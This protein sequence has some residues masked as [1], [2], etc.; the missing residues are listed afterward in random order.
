MPTE[1][2]VTIALDPSDWE[3]IATLLITTARAS[4]GLDQAQRQAMRRLAVTLLD[5]CAKEKARGDNE[6]GLTP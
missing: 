6:T 5:A 4:P 1:D 3:M 2:K